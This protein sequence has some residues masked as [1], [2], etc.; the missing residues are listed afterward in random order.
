[1]QMCT[2]RSKV[3]NTRAGSPHWHLGS[4]KVGG[5]TSTIALSQ[6]SGTED[7]RAFR[8]PS[9]QSM[10]RQSQMDLEWWMNHLKEYN[11]S[12]IHLPPP[13]MITEL[14]ASNTGWGAHWNNQK[15]GHQWSAWESRLHI[16][17]KEL[18][19]AFLSLLT[20]AKDKTGIH[21]CLRTDNLTAV[22]YINKM[23]GTHSREL[24]EI[25]AQVWEQSIH[26]NIMISAKHLPGKLNTMADHES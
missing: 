22:Y 21:V 2:S 10:G 19:A 25:T 24:M 1:M 17:A 26:R 7:P 6:S 14:D 4:N 15:T 16:N 18:L 13:E 23:G 12:P 9:Y 11:G 20:F 5:N 3:N 8:Y